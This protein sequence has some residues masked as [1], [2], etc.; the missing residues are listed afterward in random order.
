MVDSTK[1]LQAFRTTSLLTLA[2]LV[3]EFIL[4]M[5]AALFVEFP[6]SLVDGQ[7]WGW[8][9]K[10][11]PMIIAHMSVGT[12]LL[13]LALLAL[14]LGFISHSKAAISWSAA[15]LILITAAY[16]SGSIFLTKVTENTY[17]FTMAL[18]FLG[19]LLSYGAAFYFTRPP[20]KA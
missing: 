9:M 17:S 2:A 7:A 20:L 10:E 3:L 8:S 14:L 15:G 1:F 16:L 13:V 19:S 6:A 4:G 18:G 5:Y 12:L 11:S